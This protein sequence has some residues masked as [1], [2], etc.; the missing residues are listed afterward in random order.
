MINYIRSWLWPY[1]L[2]L[3]KRSLAGWREFLHDIR[4]GWRWYFGGRSD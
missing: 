1:F 3:N 2:G 4:R